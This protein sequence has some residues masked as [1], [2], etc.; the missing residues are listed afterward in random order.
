MS[1]G[2]LPLTSYK[3][4]IDFEN[5]KLKQTI[6]K[7]QAEKTGLMIWIEKRLHPFE[8]FRLKE[9]MQ[10]FPELLPYL[11]IF[12]LIACVLI[13]PKSRDLNTPD[14]K[15]EYNPSCFE[16]I[17]AACPIPPA[18]EIDEKKNENDTVDK[19]CSCQV[20]LDN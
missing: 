1:S 9:W 8:E 14:Q 20:I 6:E 4:V 15:P 12:L 11:F 17:N 19:K 18:P 10:N 3:T 5:E 7:L 16:P 2:E 13:N